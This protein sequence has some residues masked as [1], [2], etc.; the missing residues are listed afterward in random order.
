MEDREK[1]IE[2]PDR[3]TFLNYGIIDFN[4]VISVFEWDVEQEKLVLDFRK[5]FRLNYQALSLIILYVWRLNSKG[6][7]IELHHSQNS[8]EMWDRMGAKGWYPVLLDK[9]QNFIGD[10]L[11]PLIAIRDSRDFKAAVSKAEAYTQGFNIEYERTLRYVLSELLYNTLEHGSVV[12]QHGSST[13]RIPSIIQFTWYVTRNKL[14]FII[15]DLGIG[16]KEHLEQTYTSFESDVDAIQHAIKPKV[17]GTFGVVR[18]YDKKDNA[19]AGLYISSNIMRRLNANMYIVSGNGVLH[20]SPRD[21]TTRELSSRWP[22]TIVYGEVNLGEDTGFELHSL[23]S[24]LRDKAKAEIDARSQADEEDN[25][26]IHVR[27]YFGPYAEDKEAAKKFRDKNILP[28]I[29][30]NK[31]LTFDFSDVKAAPHSF[32]SALLATPILRLGMLAYKKIKVINAEPEI[33]ETIDFIMDENT[34]A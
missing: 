19:G 26:Y 32:L 10:K 21:V 2:I 12:V 9:D 11:K 28:N 30:Q 27:N 4:R 22:G 5:C 16:I 25:Y 24:E 23:M 31:S 15:A 20:I 6:I 3:F 34:E 13:R 7:Y 18:P 14:S 1:I 17:S 33:R 29:D 8:Q